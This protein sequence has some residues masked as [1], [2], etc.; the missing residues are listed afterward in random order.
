MNDF[1][2]IVIGGGAAGLTAALSAVQ[3]GKRTA[4]L[5]A[6]PRVGR[7]LLATGNGRCNLCNMGAPRY[8]G[9]RPLAEKVLAQKSAGDVLA[10]FRGIG[11]SAIEEAGGRVYPV[12]GQAASVLDA[13]RGALERAGVTVVCGAPVTALQKSGKGFSLTAGGDTYH[14]QAVVAAFGGMAGGRLGHDGTPYTLLT[15]LGHALCAPRPAL[16]QLVTEKQPVKGLSGLRLPAYLTLTA[17]GKPLA[18]AGGEVL[19]T[20]YGVS[21]VCAMQLSREADEL[22][23]R[24]QRPVLMMDFSPAMGLAPRVY[25]RMEPERVEDHTEAVMACLRERAHILPGEALLTGLL[26]RLLADKVKGL[27]LPETA[28][29]L[30]AYPVPV[31]DVRGFDNAQ[32]TAGGMA[33]REFDE[34]T[35]ESRLVPGLFAAGELMDVDGDCGGYNLLFAFASGLIAGENA[36]KAC[37]EEK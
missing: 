29:L 5:E 2:V 12:T 25:D 32:V 36:A 33:C 37:K 31:L 34:T 6:A 10:F 8:Y 23:R 17:Q 4:V 15:A 14:A 27:P 11:L 16:T 3:K 13:L 20:D 9:G 26:P 1:D 21:G 24:G 18:A 22:C 19:F 35:L 7:K 28:R 30:A